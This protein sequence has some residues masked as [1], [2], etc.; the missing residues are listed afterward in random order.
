MGHDPAGSHNGGGKRCP[1]ARFGG[2]GTDGPAVLA[3]VDVGIDAR[4][5]R[6]LPRRCVECVE[7]LAVHLRA[8]VGI[9]ARIECALGA[10]EF[11]QE[12]TRDIIGGLAIARLAEEL[13]RIGIVAQHAG[14]QLHDFL[15][16]RRAPVGLVGILIDAAPDR[17]DELQR[18]VERLA[19]H[20]CRFRIARFGQRQGI[21]HAAAVNVF[22]HIAPATVGTIIGGLPIA[23]KRHALNDAEENRR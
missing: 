6:F 14:L 7:F 2:K 23:V 5:G 16:M 18:L 17:I 20:A 3:R 19:R 8:H 10:S 9:L 21:V 12:I 1:V 22:Q 13:R 4:L 15:V 11:S